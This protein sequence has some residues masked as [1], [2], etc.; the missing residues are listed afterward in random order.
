MI[1]SLVKLAEA[2][3]RFAS[4]YCLLNVD[5]KPPKAGADIND[6][7]RVLA[8]NLD[9]I[10]EEVSLSVRDLSEAATQVLDERGKPVR[11]LSGAVIKEGAVLEVPASP[12]RSGTKVL[13]AFLVDKGEYVFGVP[14]KKGGDS[15]AKKQN[16]IEQVSAYAEFCDGEEEYKEAGKAA[17]VWVDWLNQADAPADVGPDTIIVPA[18]NGVY[19][20]FA[21]AARVYHRMVLLDKMKKACVKGTCLVCGSTK[22]V[23]GDTVQKPRLAVG[24]K[25]VSLT[26]VDKDPFQSYGMGAATSA[27]CP[28]CALGVATAIT[29]LATTEGYNYKVGE[30]IFLFFCAEDQDLVP[31]LLHHTLDNSVTPLDVANFFDSVVAGRTVKSL[32][33]SSLDVLVVDSDGTVARIAGYDKV[34]LINALENAKRWSKQVSVSSG[35]MT[36]LWALSK[37][38]LPR[39]EAASVSDKKLEANYRKLLLAKALLGKPL[40]S[41]RLAPTVMRNLSRSGAPPK[42]EFFGG[43]KQLSQAWPVS[44]T[45]LK[46][47]YLFSDRTM[48]ELVEE[49]APAYL[50]GSLVAVYCLIQEK[51]YED[52]NKELPGSGLFRESA[53]AVSRNPAGYLRRWEEKAGKAYWKH[54]SNG[55]KF[56]AGKLLGGLLGSLTSFPEVSTDDEAAQ[57]MTGF[58]VQLSQGLYFAAPEKQ[59]E[60]TAA[61][62]VRPGLPGF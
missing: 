58:R 54:L 4:T 19:L 44:D 35:P 59:E 41:R 36:P 50:L 34:P 30:S 52:R 60:A 16:Y 55:H 51:S 21:S 28:T 9:T 48:E 29:K 40:P 26:A 7:I 6:D 32:E 53:F 45:T 38:L 33:A 62:E 46:L 5:R 22:G 61:P 24:N 39:K 37:E 23:C 10:G 57:F 11:G 47:T 27:M 56:A 20:H 13:A 25:G 1:H 43:R 49:K 31:G 2:D 17:R 12:Y 15:S 8:Y 3:Y 14:G 18:V 42:S